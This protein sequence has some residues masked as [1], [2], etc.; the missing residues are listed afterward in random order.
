M[1]IAVRM[2]GPPAWG[3]FV[4][5]GLIV[6]TK[7]ADTGAYFTGRAFGRTKLCPSVS[8]NKT[9]E[10]LLGGMALACLAAWLYFGPFEQ[11]KFGHSISGEELKFIGW[12]GVGALGVGLTIAGLFGDLLESVFKRELGFKDSGTMLPGL[13]GFWDV[14]DSLLPALVIGFVIARGGLIV[15]PVP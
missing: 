14:T 4:L 11:W 10:G 2:L 13:G 15:A 12:V 5:I 7:L 3:L 8:P 9:V 6:V 1:A